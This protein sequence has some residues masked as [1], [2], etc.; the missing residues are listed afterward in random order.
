MATLKSLKNKY[1]TVSDGTAL[2]VTTNTENVSL[3]AS[4][5]ISIKGTRVLR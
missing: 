2:G 1:L 3:E 5:R 4:E